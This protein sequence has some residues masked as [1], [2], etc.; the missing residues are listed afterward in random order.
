MPEYRKWITSNPNVLF[1]KPAIRDTRIPVELILDEL[2]GGITMEE[3]IEAYP[4]L[5]IEAV[6]AALA[7]AADTVRSEV[8]YPLEP[9]EQESYLEHSCSGKQGVMNYART[10]HDCPENA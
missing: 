10:S 7:F 5:T 6:H 8:V 1:G 4:R 2:A 9:L 3:L